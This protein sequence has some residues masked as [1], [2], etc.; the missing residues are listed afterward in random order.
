MRVNRGLYQE[1]GR[2]SEPVFKRFTQENTPPV[3]YNH[4]FENN[5]AIEKKEEKDDLS[6]PPVWKEPP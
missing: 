3:L 4:G 6:K 5:Q 2:I 1:R